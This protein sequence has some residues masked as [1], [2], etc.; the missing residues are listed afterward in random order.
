MNKLTPKQNAIIYCLQNGWCL[1]TS[2]YCQYVTCCNENYQF[3][4]SLTLFWNLKNK[5]LIDQS[6]RPPHDF[7][8]TDL[9]KK[10]KTKKWDFEP[11]ENKK[12][13]TIK[14]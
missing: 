8:L 4:F 7:V 10:I 11:P 1:I 5:G 6:L 14:L 13:R 12:S 3:N 2:Y 9:G